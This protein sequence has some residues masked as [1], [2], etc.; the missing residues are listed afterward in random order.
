MHRL[1]IYNNS[2]KI[3]RFKYKQVL[4]AQRKQYVYLLFFI[5]FYLFLISN[6]FQA[7]TFYF[8]DNVNDQVNST[9]KSVY[10]FKLDHEESYI[11]AE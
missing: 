9:I 3:I 4:P 2:T 8:N 7:T 11:N 10:E 5:L 1:L 6:F